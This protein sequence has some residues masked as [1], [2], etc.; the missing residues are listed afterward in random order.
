LDEPDDIFPDD[1]PGAPKAF[2]PFVVAIRVLL[3]LLAAGAATLAVAIAV[4]ERAGGEVSIRYACPMHGQVRAATPGECPI[5]RMAL[6]PIGRNAD[7]SRR[8][9]AAMGDLAAVENV[10]RHNI[11]D[12][13]RLRSP[14]FDGREMRA[15]ASVS[16]DGVIEALFYRDQIEAI[17]VG[18]SGHFTPSASP[19]ENLPVRRTEDPATFW[20]RSTSL[21]RFRLDRAASPVGTVGWLELAP[22]PRE[23]LTAPASAVVQSPEG[24]YVLAW[25]QGFSFEKRPI[26]IGETFQ[27]QGFAVVLSGLKVNDRVVSRATFFIDADRRL[28]GDASAG[29]QYGGAP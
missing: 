4:R 9:M 20:D 10:R 19:R 21:V 3:L 24:P 23:M 7:P 27:R 5:C 12:F 26:Q 29:T 28:A 18:E 1:G 16:A 11:V 17:E 6:E 2:R 14:L 8:E 15:P 25:V 13:V 22:R